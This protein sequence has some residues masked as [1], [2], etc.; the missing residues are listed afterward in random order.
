MAVHIIGVKCLCF[1]IVR[2][3]DK[4]TSVYCSFAIFVV[5]LVLTVFVELSFVV[6]Y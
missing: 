5:A 3:V 1:C 4:H 2:C 6:F